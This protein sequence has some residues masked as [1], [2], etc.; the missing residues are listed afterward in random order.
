MSLGYEFDSLLSM[1]EIYIVQNSRCV[2]PAAF[3]YTW[4]PTMGRY[5]KQRK[6]EFEMHVTPN[7]SYSDDMANGKTRPTAEG[8]TV[9][10]IKLG[11]KE[12]TD[13]KQIFKGLLTS[14]VRDSHTT[15][16]RSVGLEIEE[17]EVSRWHDVSDEINIVKGTTGRHST[18]I[19][20][21]C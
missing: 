19:P 21:F 6:D 16:L 18:L 17:S 14:M 9:A 5:G 11:P 20:I 7:M 12:Q 1:T 10:F 15:F 4:E 2:F 3:A 13:R 8:Q